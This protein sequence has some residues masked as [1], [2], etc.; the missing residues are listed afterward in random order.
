MTGAPPARASVDVYLERVLAVLRELALEVGGPRAFHAVSPTASLEREIGLGSLERV[1]LLLRLERALDR[2]LDDRFLA[3]ETPAEIAQ[4]LLETGGAAPLRVLDRANVVGAASSAL[5]DVATIH[6][7]L[8]RR[9][10]AD[11]D[12]PHVYLHEPDGRVEEISYGRLWAAAAAIAGGLGERGVEPGDTVALM[13]PTGVDFLRSFEGIL[14]AGA[15]PVPLY[16]PVR[17]D[18][19]EEY[20]L[21]Q[22]GILSN[23]GARYLITVPQAMPVA[24][25]LRKAVP[26][27]RELTTADELAG[28]GRP[29]SGAAGTSDDPALIQYTSGSTG[30]PRGVLLTHANLLAN[31]RAIAADLELKPTDVGASWLPLYH[32]MG[33]IGTW[34]F[35]I[36]HGIP[37][38]LLSPLSFLARPEQWLWAIHHRRATLSAAPNFAYELCVRKISDAALEGLDLSSWRCALNGSEPVS[39]DTLDRFVRRFERY[40]FR[41]EAFM[42]VYGLAECSVALCVPPVGRGPLIDRVARLPCE[43]EGRAEPAATQDRSALQFL[44][45]GAPLPRH[46][47][48]IIDDTGHE[49]PERTLGHLVFRGPSAMSGYFRSPDATAAAKRPDGWLESGDLAYQSGGEIY[50]AGREKDLIIKGGRNYIPQEIEEVAGSVEGIRKGCVASFG[51]A[52]PSLGTEALVVVAETR[53]TDAEETSRLEG[54]VIARIAAEVG[55]PPDRVALV[56]AGSVPK[57][58]SGKLR[59]GTAKELYLAG[60][61]GRK[62]RL[63]LR[64]HLALWWG[65]AVAVT[66]PWL[67]RAR[68]ALYLTYLGTAFGVRPGSPC[69]HDLGPWWPFSPGG[70]R[71]SLLAAAARGSC[72]ASSGVRCQSR[73][74]RT[75]EGAAPSSWP[76]IT[77]SYIDILALVALLPMDFVFVAKREVRSWPLAGIF[78]RK[79]RHPTVDRWD[80]KQS[81]ADAQAVAQVI[82]RGDAVLFFPEGTFTAAVG[83]RPFRLGA[84][85]AAAETGVPLVPL[86]LR[87]TRRVLRDRIWLPRPGPLHL[88]IGRALAPPGK[89]W[90]SVIDLRDQTAD[91]IAAHCGE[92]RLDLVAGG[93]V[94]RPAPKPLT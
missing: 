36:Y 78:V 92:A 46:E 93:P 14:I 16:P 22:A 60:R 24:H 37:L 76:R 15:V 61:L 7:A 57:T 91:T 88:W 27:L 49:V 66:W 53:A 62:R 89:E 11:C 75:F 17:L 21:R 38:A 28:L 32:D 54:A 23:V 18:R 58:S 4:A 34:L 71:H 12:R 67:V 30:N 84:F 48:R 86:A 74:P 56:P 52:D 50:I 64:Q 85:E 77:T 9:A 33:L 80:V 20:L 51:V 8:R 13:L 65:A 2:E 59:R 5:E 43:R 79:E 70:V 47:V 72:S 26:S 55:I 1:E 82:R 69:S 90:Q 63:T 83:L 45:V 10:L 35:C 3:M 31:I 19:L 25:V 68:R 94:A 41:R 29:A 81:V 87:G 40:G 42:P 6:E 39:P 44:S 73:G